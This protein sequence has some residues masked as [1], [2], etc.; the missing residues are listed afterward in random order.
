MTVSCPAFSEGVSWRRLT[1]AE[2]AGSDWKYKTQIK[3][4]IYF[5]EPICARSYRLI[6]QDGNVRG[7]ICP[8]A[9]IVFAGYAWNGS[10]CS[11]DLPSVMLAS[12]FHDLLFQFSGC[13]GFPLS[14]WFCNNL[15][16]ALCS[17]PLGI[18][19]RI[20]LFAGS[21]AFWKRNADNLTIET[22]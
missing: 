5:A 4:A 21:W 19:Y 9:I 15:F 12:L 16:L 2:R 22:I 13:N 20:G 14:L 8:N 7:A 11:P 6:D 17:S 1:A 3:V 18:A 10:S